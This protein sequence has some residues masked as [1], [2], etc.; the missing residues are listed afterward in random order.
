MT[1]SNITQ[2]RPTRSCVTLLGITV[3]RWPR[4]AD[5]VLRVSVRR[6]RLLQAS[7]PGQFMDSETEAVKWLPGQSPNSAVLLNGKVGI[8]TENPREALDVVG[9]AV[10]TGAITQPSDR[11]VK[12]GI[13]EVHSRISNRRWFVLLVVE[14]TELKVGYSLLN[15]KCNS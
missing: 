9:N 1:T 7:N 14:F 8:N 12:E 4:Q 13:T 5:M 2:L 15:L 3:T 10:V 11:R 6:R